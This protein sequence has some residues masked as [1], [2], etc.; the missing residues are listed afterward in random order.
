VPSL[1]M[2]SLLI[3]GDTRASVKARGVAI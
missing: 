1:L 3:V 2:A